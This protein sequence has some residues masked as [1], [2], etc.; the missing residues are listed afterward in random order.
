MNHYWTFARVYTTL[1]IKFREK[2][3]PL[4]GFIRRRIAGIQKG[5][6]ITIVSNNCWGG[7][8]YRYFNLPYASPTVG[9]FFFADDYIKFLK[10][11]EYYLS[12]DLH[13][14]PL[15]ASK[16]KEALIKKNH[17]SCPIGVLDD[18][19]IIF[20]HY[21]SNEEALMKWNRRKERINLNNVIVKM[22]EM[23]KCT[24]DLLYEFDK[25]PFERKFVFVHKDYGLKSQIVCKE[26]ATKGEITNDTDNFRRHVNLISL[27]KGLEYKR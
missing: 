12:L 7:H 10:R 3:N 15:E 20:L 19:E 24:P 16:Y 25:L 27:M 17:I 26:F 5:T 4:F 1:R 18:I 11:L 14:K 23:N 13:F 22:S 8:V 21:R 6:Q 2:L 9:M